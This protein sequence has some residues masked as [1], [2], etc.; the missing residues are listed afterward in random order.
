MEYH[1]ITDFRDRVFSGNNY[2]LKE[3]KEEG[4]NN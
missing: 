2:K 4:I 1:F 3:G